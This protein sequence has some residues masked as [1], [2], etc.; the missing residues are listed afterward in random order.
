MSGM[1]INWSDAKE[2]RKAYL[3][4]L[5]P[6]EQERSLYF[7]HWK[8]L[9]EY[10][11]PRRGR[12]F[13]ESRNRGE[14]SIN[15]AIYDN[16]GT[17]ALR[18]LAAGLMSGITSPARPWFRLTTPDPEMMEFA[19][20]R[21]W[22][23]KVEQIMRT[24]FA[25]SNLYNAL[26]NVYEE[27]GLF[28]THAMHIDEDF[29]DV[30]RAY[31]MTAG[32]YSLGLSERCD[33]NAVF[34]PTSFT[35]WQ[36]VERFGEQNVSRSVLEKFK[37]GQ[38]ETW[39]PVLHAMLPNANFRPGAPGPRGKP[40]TSV[41]IDRDSGESDPTFM[42]ES[43]YNEKPFMAP[44]WTV[45]G[46]DTYGSSPAMDALGDVKQLQ[47]MQ[48]RKAEAIDKLVDP[49]LQAPPQTKN[50]GGMNNYPGGVSYIDSTQPQGGARA[51]YEVR[52][53]INGILLDIQDTRDRI[54]E[55]LYYDLFRMLATSLQG[56]REVTAREVEERHEEKLIML[57]PVLERLHGELL[58][59]LID[60]VFAIMFRNRMLPE[61]PQE[62][63]GDLL[64][65][66]Y[67]SI[68]AQ[69][70]KAVGI[71]SI[72]RLGGFVTGMAQFNPDV[73]M[74]FNFDQAVDEYA[75]MLGVPPDLVVPDEQVEKRRRA[76]AEL[77]ARQQQM[78]EQQAGAQVVR[79]L[80]QA[81]PDE[82][83]I[84]DQFLP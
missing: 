34:R 4:R 44:R 72:E 57:G 73:M 75:D 2:R 36:C 61:A 9:S 64:R 28:G 25:K 39:V 66:E 63:A 33:V 52:P 67:I 55:A 31:P 24:V 1:P 84:L 41:Y 37:R 50:S 48:L 62:I 23:H 78:A 21:S 69:A 70:Q 16:T 45:K 83:P 8:S 43:G 32:E 56:R 80:A 6:L 13:V 12:F 10:I 46:A 42:S 49:P 29:E 60:R 65:V 51:L 40:Y 38:Y 54:R 22:L 30:V 82:G 3:N 58:N 68:L 26:Y 53:D 47:F 19:P 7:D 15:A 35:V 18:T 5:N 27:L 71:S 79:D 59:P 77:Q 11:L 74:K 17:L 76:A 20:V 14:A 81:T